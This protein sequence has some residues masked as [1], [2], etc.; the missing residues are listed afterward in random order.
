MTPA[1]RFQ[2]Q[3]FFTILI[4]ALIL[5]FFIFLPYVSPLIL[6]AVFAVIFY[7]LHTRILA[8]ISPKNEHSSIAAFITLFIIIVLVLTPLLFLFTEVTLEA[9]DLYE[10]IEN[11]NSLPVF[12]TVTNGLNSLAARFMP[13]SETTLST[14]S[15]DLSTYVKKILQWVF[16][17]LDAV[18]GGAA[19]LLFDIFV[20][21]LAL[22]YMLRDGGDVKKQI[23]NYSPLIDT[24]DEKIFKKLETAINSVIKGSLLVGVIQGILTG[25]GFAIFGIPNPALWG[26]VAVFAA[27]IPGIGTSLVL[28]PGI[29]YL[30]FSSSIPQAIGLVVWAVLAVGLIDNILGPYFIRRGIQIHQFLILLSVIG[31]LAFFGPIGFILGPLVLSLLFVLLEIYR[32]TVMQASAN[33]I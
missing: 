21:F 1:N 6:A 7:P 13:G 33:K 25:I 14:E 8:K 27:L 32:S 17:H 31:G 19:R 12:D 16:S 11:G 30:V 4:G 26:S 10:R 29:L 28:I 18:F 24:Y 20:L 22:Y 5:T 15:L 23:I 3:F 2:N 9:H